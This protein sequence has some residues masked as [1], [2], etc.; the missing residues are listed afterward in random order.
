MIDDFLISGCFNN[1]IIHNPIKFNC[2]ILK[3]L[4][5]TIKLINKI[6]KPYFTNKQEFL[7]GNLRLLSF[8]FLSIFSLNSFAQMAC[9]ANFT[10]TLNPTTKTVTFTNSSYGQGVVY[11]WS[12]GDGTSSTIT[13]PI[14]IY[15]GNGPYTVCLT[16][17]KTDSSCKHS[18]CSTIV[19]SNT[20]PT[21]VST[22]T[23]TT[24]VDNSLRKLFSSTNTSLDFNYLWTFGDGTSSD[25]KTPNHL[26]AHAGKYRVCLKVMRKDSL[27][28]STTCDSI[29]VS[30]ANSTGCNSAWTL[31]ADTSNNLKKNFSSSNTSND[32]K[33]VW[34]FGDGI[35]S[36]SKTP[37]HIFPHA[38][39]YKVCLKVSKKDSTCTSTTCDSITITAPVGCEANFTYTK[40]GREVHFVNTSGGSYNRSVWKFGD[41]T[42]SDQNSTTHN[43]AVNDS[44]LV[45]LFTYRIENGDTLCQS[46]KCVAIGVAEQVVYCNA[47]FTYGVNNNLRKLEVNSTSTGN[48]LV[49]Y[50]SFGDDSTSNLQHP[51]AHV[52]THNGV[53]RVCLRVRNA[54]DSNCQSEHC[55]FIT[56]NK[57]DSNATQSQVSAIYKYNTINAANNS[58]QFSCTSNNASYAYNW[59]FGDG[60]FSSDATPLHSFSNKNWYLVCLSVSNGLTTDVICNSIA[61]DFQT[62]GIT[63]LSSIDNI[64]V[65]PNPF[66]DKIQVELGSN[67]IDKVTLMLSDISGKIIDVKAVDLTKGTNNLQFESSNIS[68]GV[69][70]L[71]ITGE[72]INKSFKLIK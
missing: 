8:L 51:T 71:N 7:I 36:D 16:V 33:Y 32:Y 70:I 64:K 61:P 42:S 24:A 67:N 58:V 52:Y 3:L 17:A 43:Y 39:R 57:I 5:L 23:F 50:W 38:G 28:T 12:Y 4:Y 56:I 48:N 59:D 10:Y 65:F 30:G 2:L 27:C 55:N 63:K 66:N 1:E 47:G 40:I 68:N 22:W 34:T 21:C 29:L 19:V 60:E 11:V 6:M 62:T 45:C 69:Y 49:Y 15:S 72:N 31:N 26:F 41:N 53:Y 20:P 35:S 44:F 37:T 14:K 46:H 54:L 25:S 13:S 9:E 18:R